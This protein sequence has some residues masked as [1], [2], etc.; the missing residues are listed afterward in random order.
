MEVTGDLVVVS[1]TW[2][3]SEGLA[4]A[5]ARWADSVGL[6]VV[7]LIRVCEEALG[8]IRDSADG[9]DPGGAASVG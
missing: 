1:A 5:F 3:D 7:L 8:A 6:A 2:E 9:A 4:V